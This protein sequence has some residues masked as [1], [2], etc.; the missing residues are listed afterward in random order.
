MRLSKGPAALAA[1][2]LASVMLGLSG[3]VVRDREVVHHDDPGYE[4]GYKEGYY[5]REHHRWW[6]DNAWH[7][8]DV[9]D[10]HCPR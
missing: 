1:F 3:C 2:G 4:Q 7:D 5:D 8:C 9:D 10:V 6:H